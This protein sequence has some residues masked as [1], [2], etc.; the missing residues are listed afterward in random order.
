MTNE[1]ATRLTGP[2]VAPSAGTADRL[3]VLLHGL[4]A[5]GRDLIGLAPALADVCPTARFVAPDAPERCDMAPMGYQWFSLQAPTS[6]SLRAGVRR[7]APILNAFIDAERDAM[8]IGDDK[9]ML[10]G[11][12][13]GT[14]MSLHVGPRRAAPLGGIVGFSGALV[15]ERALLAEGRSRPPVLLVHG[16]ADPVVDVS[17]TRAAAETFKAYGTDT[18][19]VIRPGLGHG[20]DPHGVEVAKTFIRRVWGEP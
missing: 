9:V 17:A 6:E 12:S 7:A 3:V 4:G 11:F 13:Q 16:D 2:E 8:G 1:T 20:I 15:D 5:D 14:M 19:M 10:V 18:E